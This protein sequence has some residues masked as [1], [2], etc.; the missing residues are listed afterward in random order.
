M[1]WTRFVS[2]S[3]WPLANL[4]NKLLALEHFHVLNQPI[5]LKQNCLTAIV[6]NFLTHSFHYSL[7]KSD[8]YGKH[9][10]GY[11]V[12]KVRFI[13]QSLCLVESSG[14]RSNV[15]AVVTQIRW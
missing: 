3:V 13:M 10:I 14:F 8:Q 15:V 11:P 5:G 6:H 1:I 4:R 12:T 2:A 7:N 9:V